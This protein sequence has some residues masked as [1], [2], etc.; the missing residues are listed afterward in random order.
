MNTWEQDR[1]HVINTLNDIKKGQDDMREDIVNQ[2]VE[3]ATM[4]VKSGVIGSLSA[5]VVTGVTAI[6]FFFSR[7]Q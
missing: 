2:K 6:I 3:M 7:S 5:A 4:K 1:E